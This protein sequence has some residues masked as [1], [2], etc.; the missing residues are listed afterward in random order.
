MKCYTRD[1]HIIISFSFVFVVPRIVIVIKMRNEY[2]KKVVNIV[3]T[4]RVFDYLHF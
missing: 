2:E 3:A 1:R 4:M